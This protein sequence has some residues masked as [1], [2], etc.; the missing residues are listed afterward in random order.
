MPE[1]SKD[2]MDQVT[3]LIASMGGR[4]GALISFP[5]YRP[6]LAKVIAHGLRLGF[7]DFRA[8]DLAPRGANAGTVGLDELNSA[9]LRLAAEGGAVVL[10]VE[11]LLSTKTGEQRREWFEGFI[12]EDWAK[13]LVLPLALFG[14]E[15]ASVSDR[16]LRLQAEDL[17]T[18]GLVSRLIN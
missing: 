5:D 3:E 14:H 12:R 1:K 16:V 15:A 18:Q 4:G 11:S 8:E 6:D 9:L 13:P 10:N 7:Y 17:P 2:W